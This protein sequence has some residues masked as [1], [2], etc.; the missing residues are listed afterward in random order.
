MKYIIIFI[1]ILVIVF[2]IKTLVDKHN[3]PEL[4]KAVKTKK[5]D[6]VED[7]LYRENNI[8]VKDKLWQTAIYYANKEILNVLIKEWAN[9][10]IKD[11]W[12]W[13]P[14]MVA[15]FNYE[16]D[17]V[18]LLLKNWAK[19]NEKDQF[20]Q[21]AL[22]LFLVQVE[23]WLSKEEEIKT[24]KIIKLLIRYWSDIDLK[25]DNWKIALNYAKRQEHINILKNTETK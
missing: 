7:V 10:N 20:W 8:E 14:L 3:Q 18:E 6:I 15:S 9:I 4:I 5:L 2:I 1:L 13:T 12:G 16:Y 19:I 23:L 17:N 25:D 21:T 22:I 24:D 11:N